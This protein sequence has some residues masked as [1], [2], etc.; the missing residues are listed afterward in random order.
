MADMIDKN[1]R[2]SQLISAALDFAGQFAGMDGVLRVALVGSLTTEKRHPK[3]A[4]LLL[5]IE[6]SVDMEKLAEL[7]RKLK[8]RLQSIN[9]GADIFLADTTDNYLG[10][11]CRWKDCRPGIR[12]SCKALNCGRVPYLYDDL[13]IINLP[14]KLIVDPPVV[15]SPML[16]VRSNLP[17]DLL[18]KLEEKWGPWIDSSNAEKK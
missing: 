12:M 15:L 7:G 4:D 13:Q 17:S 16:I 8:G 1:S 5:T 18:T 6:E 11:T 3:D 2:R 9:S 14:K 10:R